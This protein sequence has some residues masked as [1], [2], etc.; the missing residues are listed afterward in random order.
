MQ[1][2]TTRHIVRR[3]AAW[4][5]F[6]ALA[7]LPALACA[8]DPVEPHFDEEIGVEAEPV[9]EGALS[10]TFALKTINAT[11]VHIPVLDDQLGG[12]V[13]YRLVTR[14]W[15]E[16]QEVYTQSS[17]L[18]GG[19]NIEVAGVVTDT[20]ESNYRRVPPSTA[21]VVTLS[22]DGRYVGTGHLQLWALDFEE[23]ADPVTT[24]LPASPEDAALAPHKDRI[25]D[26]E[27][28]GNP[29]LTM[30]VSGAVQGEVYA[31][32]RKFVDLGG[33][34]LGPDRALGLAENRWESL[35]LANNNPLLDRSSE[36]SAEPHPDP[37]ESWFEEIR[38]SDE[39]D[40]D[41][42]MAISRDGSF[43]PARPF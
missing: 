20:P 5:T 16:E 43:S 14:T 2:S 7:L 4:Q 39:S 17:L 8:P 3:P 23:G 19:H 42:V 24:P 10:G 11:L 32:Q 22:G 27:D 1:T 28:D 9:E 36:G 13:N 38:I 18:C 34:V 40:C 26:F 33:V 31:I 6:S 21:E 15:D 25:F 30:F 41:D 12:G 29:G 35:M 37:K